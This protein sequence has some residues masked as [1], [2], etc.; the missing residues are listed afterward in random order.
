MSSSVTINDA[1]IKCCNIR[2]GVQRYGVPSVFGSQSNTSLEV[3]KKNAEHGTHVLDEDVRTR[4]IN[5][6]QTVP[7]AR[8]LNFIL[9]FSPSPT[10]HDPPSSMSP[11]QG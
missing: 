9:Y 11:I 1:L 3:L 4:S 6:M 8:L 2:A 10:V 7:T 5:T